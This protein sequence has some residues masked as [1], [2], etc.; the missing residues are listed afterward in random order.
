MDNSTYA[1]AFRLDGKV[2]LVTGA[3]RGIGAEIADALSEA[4]A[5]VMLTDII[6]AEGEQTVN[7]LQK[8]GRNVRFLRHEV[9]N[10][11]DWESALSATIGAFGGIDVLVNNAGIEQ[12][13]KVAE[14]SLDSF[15]KVMDVNV[16]GTF[17]G[18]K[19]AIQAMSPGGRSSRG[20]SIINLSSTA[21]IVGIPFMAG[22]STSK[23][24]VRYLTKSAA[25]ECAQLKNGIRVNSIHPG[26]VNTPLTS[27]LGTMMVKAGI[28]P[29]T[30]VFNAAVGAAHPLGFGEPRDIASATLY[31]A[32]DA[33]RWVTAT[34]LVVDG[35]FTAM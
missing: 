3:A 33:S 18:I 12:I 1:T 22:Y 2:A 28:V 16:A 23:G 10:E 35:G 19:H 14:T 30:E 6:T 32:A 31:L 8:R 34:E 11:A 25:L 26:F 20:G 9:T 17:L 7:S 29:N 13:G 15:R 24:A 4:G 21:G 27:Q 5:A